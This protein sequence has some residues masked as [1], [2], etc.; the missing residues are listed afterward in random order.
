MIR[1]SL[2]LIIGSTKCGCN[3][4]IGNNFSILWIARAVVTFTDPAD[5]HPKPSPYDQSPSRRF[6]IVSPAWIC[7]FTSSILHPLNTCLGGK[8]VFS[9]SVSPP[10][11][12]KLKA[13]PN[14]L[15]TYASD[16]GDD[17]KRMLSPCSPLK[18]QF[19]G[20]ISCLQIPLGKRV[21]M[22]CGFL[23]MSS[24]SVWC[25]VWEFTKD[26]FCSQGTRW[27]LFHDLSL[28]E[29]HRADARVRL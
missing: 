13:A 24:Q 1:P 17:E 4:T 28:S 8:F 10:L 5:T 6:S 20:T 27:Y 3:S 19:R 18:K 25:L 9:N 23:A 14:C 29:E 22:R 16:Y 26:I 12:I 15:Y 2:L 11:A 21:R 7:V